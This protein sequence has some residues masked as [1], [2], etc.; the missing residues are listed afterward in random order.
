MK[1]IAIV[2]NCQVIPL[3][4]TLSIFPNIEVDRFID[5]NR[6]GTPEFENLAQDTVDQACRSDMNIIAQPMGDDFG[7]LSAKPLQSCG[8]EFYTMVNMHFSGL[9]SDIT[10]MGAFQQRFMSPLGNYHSKIVATAYFKGLSAPYC[11]S[12]FCDATYRTLG[13]Y[14]EYDNSEAEPA[15]YQRRRARRIEGPPLGRLSSVYR[16]LTLVEPR[17]IEPLTSA[18]RLQGRD[19]KRAEM[20]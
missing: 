20:R 17:G 13:Y 10:Y 6:M 4:D 14:D 12:L 9:H 11:Q 2:G 8:A 1:K 5:I 15:R 19:S 3:A 7:C 18:V 16:L